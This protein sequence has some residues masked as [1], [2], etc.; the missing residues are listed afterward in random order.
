MSPIAVDFSEEHER[1]EAAI[2][3]M[4][5]QVEQD[6]DPDYFCWY[7]ETAKTQYRH[8]HCSC[9]YVK[10][11]PPPDPVCPFKE[12]DALKRQIDW[13]DTLDFLTYYLLFPDAAKDQ[14]LLSGP[15]VQ[16]LKY[17]YRYET[18]ECSR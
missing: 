4:S 16:R 9:D 1:L 13:L 6:P 8:S 17:E 18:C 5:D 10:D 14:M 2:A 7:D 15:E 3:K 12:W 11:P